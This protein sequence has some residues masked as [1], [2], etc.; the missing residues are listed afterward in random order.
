MT[1]IVTAVG[2]RIAI[3]AADGSQTFTPYST[4]VPQVL[5]GAQKIRAVSGLRL[6]IGMS[7]IGRVR[8]VEVFDY[9]GQFLTGYREDQP[10]D[11]SHIALQLGEGIKSMIVAEIADINASGNPDRTGSALYVASWNGDR[12][13]VARSVVAEKGVDV[14]EQSGW[15]NVFPPSCLTDYY[16]SGPKLTYQSDEVLEQQ[17]LDLVRSG[18]LEERRLHAGANEHCGGPITWAVVGADGVTVQSSE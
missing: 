2:E 17:A 7:G 8:G 18:I 12:P 3:L 5:G 16:A 9:L 13:C 14:F 4:G 1:I 10:L 11:A 6:A 15:G